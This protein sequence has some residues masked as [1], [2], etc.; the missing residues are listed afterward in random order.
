MTYLEKLRLVNGYVYVMET[1]TAVYTTWSKHSLLSLPNDARFQALDVLP[2]G[3]TDTSSLKELMPMDQFLKLLVKDPSFKRYID[4]YAAAQKARGEYPTVE[5]M[6]KAK[7][8]SQ[9]RRVKV[10]PEDIPKEQVFDVEHGY[11]PYT[12][13]TKV[14]RRRQSPCRWQRKRKFCNRRQTLGRRTN[15]VAKRLQ[16]TN[17][18]PSRSQKYQR[19]KRL[20]RLK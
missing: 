14:S 18:A 20:R 13:M 10:S 3:E 4:D 1:V 11:L 9:Q 15:K 12:R 16:S 2:T 7:V 17:I 5:H 6:L 19:S 8:A